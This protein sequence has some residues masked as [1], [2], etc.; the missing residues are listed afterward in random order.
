MSGKMPLNIS[1]DFKSRLFDEL[2]INVNRRF[3]IK[4]YSREELDN[5]RNMQTDDVLMKEY[6]EALVNMGWASLS[7]NE[8]DNYE[9]F[10]V[11]KLRFVWNSYPK[12]FYPSIS[13]SNLK[14]FPNNVLIKM[15]I[16]LYNSVIDHIPVKDTKYFESLEEIRLFEMNID[17]DYI[18][19]QK[20][21]NMLGQ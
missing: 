8:D 15:N 7:Y 17:F 19:M 12:S 3:K 10:S 16:L 14:N 5:I 21:L 1:I 6:Q 20:K 4:K 2:K 9:F 18:S 11:H 13:D